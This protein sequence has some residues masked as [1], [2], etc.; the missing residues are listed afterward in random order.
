MSAI[1]G[2]TAPAR[3][4]VL[5]DH[6]LVAQRVTTLRDV[7]TE[8]DLFRRTIRQLTWML[9][10]TAAE[11]LRTEPVPVPTPL[12]T[13]TGTKLAEEVMVV[14][15]LRAALTMV[16]AALELIPEA[17]VGFLGLERD[18]HTHEAGRY[19]AKVPRRTEAPHSGSA[20]SVLLL[21]PMLAT[22]GSAVHAIDEL[23][24]SGETRITFCGII[25]CPEGV[26]AVHAAHPEVPIVLAALDE[27][28]DANSYILPGLG[29]AGDRSFRT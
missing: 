10:P 1:G 12:T 13:T 6:P 14:G 9:V 23:K 8:A 26:A 11:S 21:D 27:R 24:A 25:G 3:L 20:R 5:S 28:L 2:T 18:E 19:Y 29:D 7:S 16:D 15:I 22:G 17:S 4:T